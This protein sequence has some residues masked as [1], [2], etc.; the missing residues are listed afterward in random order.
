[1][2]S[3]AR[4]DAVE[5]Q[6]FFRSL[7]VFEALSDSFCTELAALSV[8]V[9]LDAG[10]CLYAEGDAPTHVWF[11]AHGRLRASAGERLLG[12]IGRGEPVGEIGVIAGAPREASVTALRDSRLWRV[13]A[14]AFLELLRA[15]AD[16]LLATSKLLITRMRESDRQRRQVATGR[17]GTFAVVPASADT[18]VTRL[19]ETLV[20]DL[21]GW[22]TVRLLTARHV[23]AAL[24]A[25]AAAAAHDGGDGAARIHRYLAE[26]ESRH[27]YLIL[28]ADDVDSA[29][30][31]CC[32][33]QADRILM[34]VEAEASPRRPAALDE[35]P[36][37]SLR[38]PIELVIL[39]SDGDPSP[40]TRA[41]LRAVEARAHYFVHPW[42]AAD[43]AALARQISGRGLGLVLGGGGAR[44]FAHIGLLRA[45][46]ELG[47][48]V[49]V[50]GGTSMGAFVAALAACGFD[51]VE[52]RQIARETFV[53]NNFLND[54]SLPRVSLIRGQ[55]FRSRLA[56]I[57]G[58]RLIEDLR[59]S[60]YCISTNLTTGAT[61][62]HQ[63]GPLRE[64]VGV[65]M[66]VPGVA[67]PIAHEG[68][69]LC[70]GGV[71]DNLPTD[72]MQDLERGTILACNV[73]ATG[74]LAAPGCGVDGPDPRALLDWRGPRRRPGFGE[75][76]LRTATLTSDTRIARD[77]AER[78]DLL[79]TMPV[80]DTGM[81]D[82]G[83][84]DSLIERGYTHAMETLSPRL[85]AL[86]KPASGA[87]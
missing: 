47:V 41:W 39:R 23:D 57:F 68:E 10:A 6:S 49:D 26:L 79:I 73:S 2:T 84:L 56:E 65:S 19:A 64:W 30:A 75:I 18:P 24:G 40:H 77:A 74:D 20:G 15:H 11:L 17:Q 27:R 72:V 45:L 59:R 5:A 80:Q 33:R 50:L 81:F 32:L 85:A 16:A 63:H 22:P 37:A 78:A 82:W 36:P 9:T 44:G 1:M 8:P 54:Y 25:G 12:L 71:V 35:L 55:R 31:R 52:M 46:D 29:W 53:R 60:Y 28:V 62:A 13:D 51:P 3:S 14:A 61:M 58:A 43:L 34:L 67:P 76:L 38:A 48:A 42:H 69:L 87:S 21:G 66:A 83:A 4:P 7:S 86:L 70:D